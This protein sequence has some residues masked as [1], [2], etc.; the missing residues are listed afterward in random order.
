MGGINRL[1]AK[2]IRI[3]EGIVVP[4]RCRGVEIGCLV[5]LDLYR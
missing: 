3:E 5:D 4:I 1:T 2:E